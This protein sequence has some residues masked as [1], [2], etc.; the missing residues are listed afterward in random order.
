MRSSA[1]DAALQA[2]RDAVM[3]AP[4]APDT[5]PSDEPVGTLEASPFELLRAMTGRRSLSQIRKLAWSVDPEP[6]LPAFEFGP[7]TTSSVDI[8]E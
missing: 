5:A 1:V 6:Y 7:F 3:L 4:D 8:E 2:A